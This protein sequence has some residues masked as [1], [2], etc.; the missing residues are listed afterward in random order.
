MGSSLVWGTGL[1]MSIPP[2]W[3]L[4]P[5]TH[6]SPA[7]DNGSACDPHLQ[8]TPWDLLGL[9]PSPQCSGMVLMWGTSCKWRVSRTFQAWAGAETKNPAGELQ[10]SRQAGM[11]WEGVGGGG[12]D[13]AGSQ[14]RR[15]LSGWPPCVSSR[16]DQIHT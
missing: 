6:R 5:S 2:S 11:Y 16:H 9:V 14:I 1:D 8:V 13:K 7:A 3:G 15:G 4:P 10:V 12:E